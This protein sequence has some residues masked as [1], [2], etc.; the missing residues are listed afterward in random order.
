MLQMHQ[1]QPGGVQHQQP[2]LLHPLP[3]HILHRPLHQAGNSAIPIF[4]N[5]NELRFCKIGAYVLRPQHLGVTHGTFKNI[6]LCSE[7]LL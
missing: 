6:C 1:H 2:A 3:R 7:N 5:L 4:Q